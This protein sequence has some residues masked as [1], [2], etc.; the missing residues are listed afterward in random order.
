[1][2]ELINLKYSEK[3]YQEKCWVV[4]IYDWYGCNPIEYQIYNAEDMHE[5][6]FTAV[7]SLSAIFFS[8]KNKENLYF[9]DDLKNN[10]DFLFQYEA[11]DLIKDERAENEHFLGE[12]GRIIRTEQITIETFKDYQDRLHDNC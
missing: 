1:M 3:M 8:A 2:V 4:T 11:Q 12:N 5:A 9:L 10:E 6:I 7:N